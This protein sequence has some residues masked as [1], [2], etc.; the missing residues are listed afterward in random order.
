MPWRRKKTANRETEQQ[1]S[2]S[3]Q[4]THDEIEAIHKKSEAFSNLVE[5]KR[6]ED[7]LEF[8]AEMEKIKEKRRALNN[9]I[10]SLEQ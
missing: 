7:D 2:I 8:Q 9:Y 4:S 1:R 6:H 3:N 10:K 5:R